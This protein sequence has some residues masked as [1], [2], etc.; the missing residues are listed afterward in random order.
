MTFYYK[1]IKFLLLNTMDVD[2][3][4]VA[5]TPKLRGYSIRVNSFLRISVDCFW[6]CKTLLLYNGCQPLISRHRCC[7][8]IV[9]NYFSRRS[10]ISK[11]WLRCIVQFTKVLQ[12]TFIT[13]LC[14]P[15]TQLHQIYLP[16]FPAHLWREIFVFGCSHQSYT[17]PLLL[18]TYLFVYQ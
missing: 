5:L 17:I 3:N 13:Y 10:D 11:Y 18:Y 7:L 1:K 12:C 15:I 2:Q 4:E 6:S 9:A 16:L 14:S 8:K